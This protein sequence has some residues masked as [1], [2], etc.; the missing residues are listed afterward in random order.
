MDI[1]RRINRIPPFNNLVLPGC[2]DPLS[3]LSLDKAIID[4][5]FTKSILTHGVFVDT[6]LE[7]ASNSKKRYKA[8]LQ[9]NRQ[10]MVSR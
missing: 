6:S 7:A 10:A 4:R 9:R 5:S 2:D 8:K 1:K 3:R